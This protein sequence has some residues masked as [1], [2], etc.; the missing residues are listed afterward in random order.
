ML[1]P[2]LLCKDSPDTSTL[3]YPMY[4][5]PKLDGIRA[6]VVN[7][8]VMSRTMK[9]IPNK[10][11]QRRFGRAEYEGFD[12]ELIVGDPNDKDVY[13]KTV[14]IVM[15]HD[16]DAIDVEY[17][18]FDKYDHPGA[19]AE[20]Y[21]AAGKIASS[22]LLIHNV[23]FNE[24]DLAQFEMDCLSEGYEGVVIRSSEGIYKQ[25]RTTAKENIAFKLKR[26]LDSEAV[27]IGTE[28]E[29]HNTN[30]KV[31]NELGRGQRS[32][33]KAGLVGKGTMGALIVRDVV[34]G[35]VFNI[36]SGFNAR[37]R[38]NDWP[39]G[40]IVKY[41]YFPVGVKDKPRHPIY[42]GIRDRMDM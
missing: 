37:E 23:V 40:T 1:K 17:Y 19:F 32:T 29:M 41:K 26:Y 20:R 31:T 39:D 13:R 9:E 35:V 38:L 28:E 18:V 42:L 12:G 34:T 21:E 24:Q 36:G 25:G 7:G 6:L 22:M 8:R 2:M 16:K 10:E 4:A 3:K 30:E 33:H 14:S 27:V 11:I 5:S 15:A